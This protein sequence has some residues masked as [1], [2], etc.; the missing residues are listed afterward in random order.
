MPVNPE[1][2]GRA[3]PPTTPY[4]VGREKVREFARAVFATDPQHDDPA[5]AEALGYAD[6]V[7]P[8]TF[9]MVVQDITLQQLLAEPDSGIVLERVV[10]AEQRFRY[11]RPIVAGD[12]LSAQ[13][14]VTGIRAF[15][16]GAMV[17]SEAEITDAAGDHVVTATSVLLVGGDE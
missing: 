7:A 2:Q 11:T 14:T 9:A 17:T 8:P 13:L 4:L 16:K 5:A 12:E 15:G 6:V 3:F 10:H 1:L